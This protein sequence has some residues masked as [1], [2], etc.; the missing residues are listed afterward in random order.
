MT[1]QKFLEITDDWEG[2][3]SGGPLPNNSKRLWT[4]WNLSEWDD[5]SNDIY[6]SFYGTIA[7]PDQEFTFGIETAGE[8]AMKR[9]L[10]FALLSAMPAEAIDDALGLLWESYDFAWEDRKLTLTKP[11]ASRI[12]SGKVAT[13]AV[14]PELVISE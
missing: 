14:R 1:P 9:I 6:A 7:S 5:E 8:D 12:V 10:G 4:Q 3:Y 13:R 2:T 11:T